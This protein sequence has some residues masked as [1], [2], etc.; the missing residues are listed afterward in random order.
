[1]INVFIMLYTYIMCKTEKII[2]CV[3]YHVEVEMKHINGFDS[4]LR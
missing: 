2:C 3:F 1:V 4:K